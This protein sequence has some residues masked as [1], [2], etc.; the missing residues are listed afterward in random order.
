MYNRRPLE[1]GI[2]EGDNPV[3]EIY[4]IGMVFQLEYGGTREIPSEVIPT[5][6]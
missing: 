2:T 3:D 4:I 6:G 1:R 5:M